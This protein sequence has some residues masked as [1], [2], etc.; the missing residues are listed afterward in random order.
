MNHEIDNLQ[1]TWN[2]IALEVDGRKMPASAVTGS[3]IVV[4]GETFSTIAMGATYEGTL[5]VDT[6]KSPRT[7]NMRFS[8]GPEKG[9][10][11]FAIYELDGDTWTICIN[12][13]GKNRP[14]KFATSPGSG[15]A[16]ETLKR[17]KDAAVTTAPLNIDLQPVPELEG[18]W[19][20]V[21]CVR[22]GYPLEPMLLKSGRRIGKGSETTTLF[23]SQV[24]MKAR[25]AV[26][27]TKKP[28][29]IDFFL[30]DGQTQHGIY[31]MEGANFKVCFGAPGQPRPT[32]FKSEQGDGRTLTV[33]TPR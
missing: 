13:T 29:T 2:I 26:D 18:D 6:A 21:S 25:Y 33:W 31:E 20:M 1:G 8:D 19:R 10:T 32:E 5:E 16:L 3:K 17:G 11:N 12:M 30:G 7:L 14:T 15:H 24:F 22:D 23:G 28:K 27:R 9:N 4:K